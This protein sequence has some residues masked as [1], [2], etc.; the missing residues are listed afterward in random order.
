MI[1][2]PSPTFN[3]MVSE[4]TA[5]AKI[6][7]IDKEEDLAVIGSGKAIM[8]SPP[9]CLHDYI[10]TLVLE[11]RQRDIEDRFGIL[12]WGYID[13][14]DH[15]DLFR[16]YLYVSKD[17]DEWPRDRADLRDGDFCM[18]YVDNVEHPIYSEFGLIGI[19]KTDIG[20]FR[21]S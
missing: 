9:S 1:I 14:V 12:I 17:I 3:E 15:E 4:A 19:R 10:G 8:F 7:G 21:T 6:L 11:K 2:Y 5:R 13:A 18:A 20:W 16:N